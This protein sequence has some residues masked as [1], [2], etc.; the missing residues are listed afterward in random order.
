MIVN[1]LPAR[2]MAALV[3]LC[4]AVFAAGQALPLHVQGRIAVNGVPHNTGAFFKFALVT[5]NN[6]TL[7]SNDGT[8]VNG[9][10]PG[11]VVPLQVSRGLWSVNL[12]D[13]AVPGMTQPVPPSLFVNNDAVYLRI[14]FNDGQRGVQLLSPDQR[15]A[16]VGYAL[17]A[18]TADAAVT[19]TGPVPL[20]LLPQGVILNNATAVN[21][22]GTFSGNGAGLN[23]VPGALPWQVVTGRAIQA[24]AQKG[25]L[26]TSDGTTVRLPLA[27]QVG[28]VFRVSGP[29]AGGWRVIQNENQSIKGSFTSEVGAVWFPR[30]NA[31]NWSSISMSADGTRLLA[32]VSGGSIWQSTD[33]GV[34]WIP[35]A[36]VGQYPYGATASSA[37]GGTLVVASTNRYV[38]V[39][40]DS[41]LSWGEKVAAGQANWSA[42]ASSQAGSNLVATANGGVIYTSADSGANWVPR[43]SSRPWQGVA[44]SA[45]GTNLVAVAANDFIWASG[46]AGQTWGAFAAAGQRAW[47]AVAV[48]T[49]TSKIIAVTLGG[50]VMLSA[51]SGAAWV[52][53][54]ALGNGAWSSVASSEDGSILAVTKYG[55]KIYVSTDS[56]A[57]WTEQET[58]RNWTSIALSANGRRLAAT[59]ANG[60]IFVSEPSLIGTTTTGVNG[61]LTGSNYSAVELQYAGDNLF[62]PISSAGTIFA[63]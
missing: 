30:A 10:E 8:S 18:Q 12:G 20:N 45:N 47:R 39:S 55:G 25:Y 7:W 33:F 54:T 51:N 48:N 52:A 41:G 38:T 56:G 35:R 58:N 14:W 59:V 61:Y 27:P 60:N 49:N 37:D 50:P 11:G 15:I 3:L 2:L 57:T 24:E 9:S 19:L 46:N 21:L 13:P 28:D 43:A 22:T 16:A 62:F 6:V 1:A 53:A 32:V 31:R 29:N 17:N 4:S 26:V 44:S 42:V 34:N 36:E 5:A 40:V 63:H 23:N